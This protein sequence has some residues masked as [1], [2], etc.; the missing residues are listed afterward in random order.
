[1]LGP[2]FDEINGKFQYHSLPMLV[3]RS[4]GEWLPTVTDLNPVAAADGARFW[5]Y[6]LARA[7]FVVYLVW[8][9]KRCG[10]GATSARRSRWCVRCPPACCSLR[11]CW[12]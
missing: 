2:A 3:Q 10:I 11:C 12:S 5:V 6:G 1:M 9:L 4:I 8:E 7:F